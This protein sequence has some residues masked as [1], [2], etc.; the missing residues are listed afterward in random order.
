MCGKNAALQKPPTARFQQTRAMASAKSA[1]AK[2]PSERLI[3]ELTRPND[4]YEI[5]L[6]ITEAGRIADRLQL[7]D[8][9]LSGKRSAWMHVRTGRDQVLEVR[10][11]D[12]LREARQQTAALVRLLGQIHRQRAN[13]P[14]PDPDD[15]LAGL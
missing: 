15:D 2:V 8:E 9:L 10:V 1:P 4:P 12:P 13:I 11:N 6:M 5:T 3:S 14:G 7:I